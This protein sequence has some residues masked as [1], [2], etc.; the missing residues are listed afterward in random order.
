MPHCP[1]GQNY[2]PQTHQCQPRGCPDGQVYNPRT[3][4]CQPPVG[5]C[6]AGQNYNADR[7]RCEPSCNQGQTYNPQQNTCVPK[8]RPGITALPDCGPGPGPGPGS[9]CDLSTHDRIGGQCL[10]KCGPNQFRN[11]DTLQCVFKLKPGLPKLPLQPQCSPREELVNGQCVFK[12]RP[13]EQRIN[14]QCVRPPGNDNNPPKNFKPV[15]PDNGRPILPNNGPLKQACGGDQEMFRG[16]CVAKC[17]GDQFRGRNGACV[18][19]KNGNDNNLPRRLE[20]LVSAGQIIRRGGP[21]AA[22]FVSGDLA[23]EVVFRRAG[24]AR[25]HDIA[26]ADGRRWDVKPPSIS[27]ASYFVRPLAPVRSPRR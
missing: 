17:S 1:D 18:E 19:S 6:P 3:H 13:G 2:N 5:Q 14:G 11:R 15:L 7:H 23:G 10:P 12:C 25:R 20:I 27:G 26:G 24:D 9:Q 8:C 22:P 16:Q 4:Q 21:R